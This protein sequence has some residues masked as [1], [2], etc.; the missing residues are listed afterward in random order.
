MQKFI[1]LLVV[2]IVLFLFT[3]IF[4]YKTCRFS[5]IPAQRA[6]DPDVNTRLIA[7]HNNRARAPN[8]DANRRPI[9]PPNN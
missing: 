8:A 3:L 9:V 2:S 1:I 5:P 6:P 7:P 4:G